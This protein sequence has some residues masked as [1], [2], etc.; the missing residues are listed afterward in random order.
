MNAAIGNMTLK[1]FPGIPRIDQMK[2][3]LRQE[4]LCNL[5]IYGK[6]VHDKNDILLQFDNYVYKRVYNQNLVDIVLLLASN[7]W[8]IKVNVNVSQEDHYILYRLRKIVPREGRQRGEID[9]LKT[10]DI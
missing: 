1:Q 3:K 8:K 10:T 6:W 5:D 4:L 7:D 9:L 2:L